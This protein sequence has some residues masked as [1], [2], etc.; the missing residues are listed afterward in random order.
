VQPGTKVNVPLTNVAKAKTTAPALSQVPINPKVHLLQAAANMGQTPQ[1]HAMAKVGAPPLCGISKVSTPLPPKA[2]ILQAVNHAST[3][4]P[5]TPLGVA[6]P[7]PANVLREHAEASAVKVLPGQHIPAS[8]KAQALLVG[9]GAGAAA[10]GSPPL[11]LVQPPKAHHVIHGGPP[12]I[13]TGAV[14]SPPLKVPGSHP[15]SQQ[16]VITGASSFRTAVPKPQVNHSP[17][18]Q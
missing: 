18:S 6:L 16:P 5:S 3:K 14:A 11:P 1:Q 13:L 17:S 9:S 2:H 4:A 12:P 7:Q 15:S 8:P 10:K